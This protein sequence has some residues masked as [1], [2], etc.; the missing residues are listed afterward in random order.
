MKYVEESCAKA[1]KELTRLRSRYLL[2]Q[3]QQGQELHM[4]EMYTLHHLR[5]QSISPIMKSD[6][7][8]RRIAM[9][10]LWDTKRRPA[11][12]TAGRG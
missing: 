12:G 1:Q 10:R 2:F 11:M 7:G 9:S 3:H 6:H 4:T 8:N 5:T